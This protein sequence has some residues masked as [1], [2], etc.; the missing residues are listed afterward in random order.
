MISRVVVLRPTRHKIGHFRDVSSCQSL[1]LQWKKLSLTQQKSTHSPIKRNSL[2]HKNT[3]ARSSRLLR[4]GAGLFSKAST[5]RGMNSLHTFSHNV[6]QAPCPQRHRIQ[7]PT[8]VQSIKQS[9]FTP[10][11][12]GPQRHRIQPP[13]SVQSMKQSDFTP[14]GAG[15]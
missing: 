4:N 9:D 12:A 8:S 6:G 11:G 14:G 10:G 5:R 1:G 13:T 2:Q 7:P 3:K 15:P